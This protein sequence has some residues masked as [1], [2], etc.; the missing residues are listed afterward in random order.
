MSMGIGAESV[1]AS[2]MLQLIA[3]DCI[4]VYEKIYMRTYHLLTQ[5][6]VSIGRKRVFSRTGPRFPFSFL[7]S[8]D[9]L[10]KPIARKGHDKPLSWIQN[11]G[12]QPIHEISIL[13]NMINY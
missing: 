13:V 6:D 3:Y 9:I 7:T 5:M 1:S 10:E 11:P 12:V 8:F 2:C 4:Y